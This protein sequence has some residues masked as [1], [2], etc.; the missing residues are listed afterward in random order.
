MKLLKGEETE[1]NKWFSENELKK[2]EQKKK[3]KIVEK[4]KGEW[5]VNDTL[6]VK[7]KVKNMDRVEVK[8][9]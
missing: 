5:N 1:T 7:L 8:V 3:L 2:L 6:S 4:E 9:F